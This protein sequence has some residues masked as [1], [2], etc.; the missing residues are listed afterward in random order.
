[1]I[2]R[3]KRTLTGSAAALAALMLFAAPASAQFYE[4]GI[5]EAPQVQAELGGQL[6]GDRD[7][8]HIRE[9]P[10]HRSLLG[11]CSPLVIACHLVP[12]G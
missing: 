12:P 1:M 4:E 5:G 10:H 8:R 3:S 11:A 6:H 7:A 9:A 2:T